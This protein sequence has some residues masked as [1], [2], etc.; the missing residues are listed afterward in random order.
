VDTVQVEGSGGAAI[1]TRP[2][3]RGWVVPLVPWVVALVLGGVLIWIMPRVSASRGASARDASLSAG[4]AKERSAAASASATLATTKAQLSDA[5]QHIRAMKGAAKRR[6]AD[7]ARLQ[8][9]AKKLRA[10]KARLSARSA[11]S[12]V[13]P[14]V[15][16]I[17]PPPPCHIVYYPDG[18]V[19]LK[20]G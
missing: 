16:S 3:T 6:A 4:V 15:G 14:I 1:S 9:Q 11:A 20:C 2:R 13:G 5:T 18:S 17:G 8:A 19:G 10:E 12:P 7:V